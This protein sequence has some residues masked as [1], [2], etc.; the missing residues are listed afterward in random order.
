MADRSC[1]EQS[2][3]GEGLAM[4]T[5]DADRFVALLIHRCQ[6][7]HRKVTVLSISANITKSQIV[8]PIEWCG[9]AIERTRR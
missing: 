3:V 8:V 6:F 5:N 7:Q 4:L 9:R 2:V 1:K